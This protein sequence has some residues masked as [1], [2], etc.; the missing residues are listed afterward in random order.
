MAD[1][2]G[3]DE[4]AAHLTTVLQELQEAAQGQTIRRERIRQIEQF[5]A[6]T[7]LLAGFWCT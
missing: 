7:P 3:K 6:E 5:E 4:A 2:Q 1:S